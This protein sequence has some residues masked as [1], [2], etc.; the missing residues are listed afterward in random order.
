MKSSFLIQRIGYKLDDKVSLASEKI[1]FYEVYFS[2]PS[3][4]FLSRVF[5]SVW[6]IPNS[7]SSVKAASSVKVHLHRWCTVYVL[8]SSRTRII[9]LTSL[10]S[11]SEDGCTLLAKEWITIWFSHNTRWILSL[12]SVPYVALGKNQTCY[13]Q[14]FLCFISTLRRK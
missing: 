8:P 6:V 5:M 14:T 3:L 13:I 12:N 9:H 4:W 2:L 10:L 7:N 11:L 1:T